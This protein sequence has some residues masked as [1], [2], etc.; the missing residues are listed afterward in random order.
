M[1]WAKNYAVE[2]IQLQ[3]NSAKLYV[4]DLMSWNKEMNKYL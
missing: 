4:N 1:L 3:F 2:Q